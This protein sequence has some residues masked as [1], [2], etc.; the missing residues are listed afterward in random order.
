MDNKTVEIRMSGFTSRF[1]CRRL[2][3]Q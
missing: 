2:T 3:V 1:I